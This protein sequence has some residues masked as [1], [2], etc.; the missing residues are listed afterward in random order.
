V[1]FAS[2]REGSLTGI[3]RHCFVE[4]CPYGLQV[5]EMETRRNLRMESSG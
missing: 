1:G 5:N 3:L 4:P 2:G